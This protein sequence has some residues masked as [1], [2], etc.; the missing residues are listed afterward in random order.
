M[1]TAHPGIV[2]PPESEFIVKLFPRYGHIRSFEFDQAKSFLEDILGN[3]LDVEEQWEIKIDLPPGALLGLSYSQ[4]AACLYHHYAQIKGMS[5]SIWGDKNNCHGNY[6]DLLA[7]LYP[8]AKFIHLVRDGR[9]CLNSYKKLNVN[10]NQPY[11]P[12]LP[13]DT[14]EVAFRWVDMVDRIDRHLARYVQN[15]NRLE[16]RYE[17]LLTNPET[18]LAQVC[19]FIGVEFD[20]SMLN[21]HAENKARSLE[22]SRYSWKENTFKPIDRSTAEKWRTDLSEDEICLFETVAGEVLIRHGYLSQH[23]T[24]KDVERPFEGTRKRLASRLKEVLRHLRV[25]F[26]QIRRGLGIAA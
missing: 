10:P 2:I 12:L 26:V 11:A 13:K 21:Y 7:W 15:E 14:E 23:D 8:K 17:D 6:I 9:A 16:V 18:T 3:V 25:A 4:A 20:S 24:G 5:A 19:D 22:P 1:L